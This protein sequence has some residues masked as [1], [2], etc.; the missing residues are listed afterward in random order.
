MILIKT[1]SAVVECSHL[2]DFKTCIKN[3]C[4]CMWCD[5]QVKSERGCFDD[6]PPNCNGTLN[7]GGFVCA[8]VYRNPNLTTELLLILMIIVGVTC[9]SGIFERLF[10]RRERRGW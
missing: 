10:Q 9:L 2:K 8:W 6:Y 5:S 4:K 1:V 7:E 3:A